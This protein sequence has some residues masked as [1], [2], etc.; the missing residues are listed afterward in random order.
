MFEIIVEWSSAET[1]PDLERQTAADLT[2]KLGEHVL[3]RG[4]D[5]WS[6]TLT[7]RARV[8]AYPMAMWLAS[9]WWRIR[10]EPCPET[11]SL[12][13][14]RWRLAHDLPAAGHGY[15]WPS[16]RLFSDGEV[17]QVS[18]RAGGQGKWESLQYQTSVGTTPV[19]VKLF[20]EAVDGFL[21]VTIERLIESGKAASELRALWADV[22]AERRDPEVSAW[23]RLE[24]RL[25]FD[26]DEAPDWLMNEISLLSGQAGQAAMDEVAPSIG[27]EGSRERLRRINEMAASPGIAAR[28]RLCLHHEDPVGQ[29]PWDRGRTLAREVRRQAAIPGGPVSNETLTELLGLPTTAL[30]K[31]V[32]GSPVLG[33]GIRGQD[34]RQTTLHFRRRSLTGRRFEAARFLADHL[35]A[36]PDDRWLPQTDAVTAR[37]KAQRAF[38]AELLVPIDDLRDFLASDVTSEAIEDA[39]ERYQV[40]PL[41]VSAHLKNHGILEGDTKPPF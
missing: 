41:A 17:M 22:L 29:T 34:D 10:H 8:S 37:Q 39:G 35:I 3:T 11:S 1:A 38:A 26:A 2:L 27:A 23:R 40:S 24:A 30:A 13:P 14:A 33:L 5:T 16:V 9:C 12:P 32:D 20:D 18:A 25:G 7:D 31:P 6:R 21:D 36:G 4:Q 19:A 28:L 15:V